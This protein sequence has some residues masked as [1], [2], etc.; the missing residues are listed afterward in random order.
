MLKIAI[1]VRATVDIF[2]MLECSAFLYS[3]QRQRHGAL[4]LNYSNARLS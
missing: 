2:A 4:H 1:Y 3:F